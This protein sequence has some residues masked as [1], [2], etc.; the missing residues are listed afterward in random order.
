MKGSGRRGGESWFECRRVRRRVASGRVSGGRSI[1]ISRRTFATGRLWGG[2]IRG[3]GRSGGRIIHKIAISIRH[4]QMT[5]RNGGTHGDGSAHDREVAR[6]RTSRRNMKDD[7]E[8]R[9]KG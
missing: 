7:S 4:R 6:K 8:G 5:R 1:G 3:R 2:R 9:R